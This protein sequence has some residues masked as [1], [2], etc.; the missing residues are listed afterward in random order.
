MR[1]LFCLP[2]IFSS[3]FSFSQTVD[4]K[5]NSS[6]FSSN[7]INYVVGHVELIYPSPK[8][9]E[10]IEKPQFYP[11]PVT[12]IL[13]FLD[14]KKEMVVEVYN[15]LGQLVIKTKIT[16]LINTTD[17]NWIVNNEISGAAAIKYGYPSSKNYKAVAIF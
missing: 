2:L 15:E 7:S 13:H 4:F 16:D 3:L 10:T 9:K 5:L 17:N 8:T 6:S 11:N 12:D 14:Y 1:K